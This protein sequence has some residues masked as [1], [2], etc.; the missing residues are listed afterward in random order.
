MFLYPIQHPEE[1]ECAADS[2][3]CY[4]LSEDKNGEK[5]EFLETAAAL[6]DDLR[7]Q[8]FA[9]LLQF[10]KICAASPSKPIEVIIDDEK[11]CHSVG[12]VSVFEK[13]GKGKRVAKAHT[14]WQFRYKTLRIL[15]AYTGDGRCVLLAN[16]VEK[17]RNKTLRTWVEKVGQHL[18]ILQD[19]RDNETLVILEHK[20][21]EQTR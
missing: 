1:P 9:W 5:C 16:I 17:R 12:T 13:D 2:W 6:G 21:Y 7:E 4:A 15:W 11:V 18:Q 19:H 3:K 10:R 20:K 8:F 14:V